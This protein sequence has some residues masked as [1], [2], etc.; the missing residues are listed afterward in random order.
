MWC[1]PEHVVCAYMNN[2]VVESYIYMALLDV[3]QERGQSGTSKGL[4]YCVLNTR[5]VFADIIRNDGAAFG[6]SGTIAITCN[7]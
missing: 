7:R 1:K 2:D 6:P 4:H 3:K 5:N